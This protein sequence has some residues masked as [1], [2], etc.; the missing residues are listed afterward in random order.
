[1]AQFEQV[2]GEITA[3]EHKPRRRTL[4]G[5]PGIRARGFHLRMPSIPVAYV[6]GRTGVAYQVDSSLMRSFQSH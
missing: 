6:E 1:M 4:S 2:I 5:E 3:Q